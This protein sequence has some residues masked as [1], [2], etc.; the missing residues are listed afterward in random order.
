MYLVTRTKGEKTE[1]LQDLG[2][3]SELETK[4]CIHCDSTVI[5]GSG[6]A[7]NKMMTSYQCEC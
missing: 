6:K 2:K 7:I 5:M 1:D 4:N 3:Y